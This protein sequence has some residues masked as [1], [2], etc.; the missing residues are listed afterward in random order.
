VITNELIKPSL[1]RKIREQIDLNKKRGD[2]E[3][4]NGDKWM[5]YGRDISVYQQSYDCVLHGVPI[6]E[7]LKDKPFI[8]ALDF[9]G[10][11][12][13]LRTLFGRFFPDK[14][15]FGLA[16]S[17]EDQRSVGEKN[18]DIS[19]NIKQMAGDMVQPSIWKKIKKELPEGYKANLIMERALAGF[20]CFPKDPRLFA[21]I[22]NEVWDLLGRD[23]DILLAGVPSY[24]TCEAVNMVDNFKKY[25]LEASIGQAKRYYYIKLIKTPD[26]PEKLPFPAKI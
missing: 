8:L 17:L 6:S 13:A 11:S 21:I 25:N 3:S 2:R 22:L 5:S 14:P 9:M 26:S 10:P 23:R 7:F 18:E 24:M 4:Y 20:D 19:L 16:I 12:E 1:T 15:K